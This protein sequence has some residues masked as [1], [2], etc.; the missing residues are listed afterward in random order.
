MAEEQKP[1]F[2]RLPTNVVPNH[3]I[4]HLNPN[5]KE[6]KFVGRCAINIEIK[7]CTDIIK[8]NSSELEI[9]CAK[10]CTDKEEEEYECCNF[11]Y[12][13]ENE[14][15]SLK[16]SK[17]L[18][19]MCATLILE[20]NGILNDRMQ[21]FYRSAY[22]ASEGSEKFAAV[23]QFEPTFARQCF[24]CW[25]EPALKA[26]FDVKLTVPE[27]MT[28]LSNM[29]VR[30]QHTCKGNLHVTFETSPIMSTYLLAV[31]IGEY[32]FVEGKSYEGVQVRVFTPVGKKDLGQY[33][34]EIATKSL[35]FFTCYFGIEYPLKKLD[36]VGVTNF[37]SGA[38][39][40]WGLVTFREKYILL[41][42]NES[43][44][45]DKQMLIVYVG[46]EIAHQWFGNLVTMEWWTHLWLNEGYA[47]FME[48]LCVQQMMPDSE[49]WT[50]FISGSFRSALLLDAKENSHPIEIEIGHPSEIA[51]T[52]DDISYDKGATLIKMLHNFLGEEDFQL[53]IKAYL[54]KHKYKNTQTE[55]LWKAFEDA[56]GK[57]VGDVMNT[58]TKQKGYPILKVSMEQDGNTRI[59][60]LKQEKFTANGSE[61]PAKPQWLI[62]IRIISENYRSQDRNIPIMEKG[63]LRITLTGILELLKAYKTEKHPTVWS[64]IEYALN[65]LKKL[66]AF[67][68]CWDEF[69]LFALDLYSEIKKNVTWDPSP[70]DKH[71][72]GLLRQM[73][74]E[75]LVGYGDE[76]TIKEAKLRYDDDESEKRKLHADLKPSAI[77]AILSTTDPQILD[78]MLEKY[79]TETNAAFKIIILERLSQV[80]TQELLQKILDFGWGKDVP[81]QDFVFIICGVAM[82]PVRENAKWVS[83]DG[84]ELKKFLAENSKSSAS[85]NGQNGKNG[86]GKCVCK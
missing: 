51:E 7:E 83:R 77:R 67:A 86:T 82:N 15:V 58:W 32:D 78:K 43:T 41:D 52:F 5:L 54:N 56:S 25:D 69:R 59:V 33:C 31:V 13:K 21:G 85:Q 75:D 36:L 19:C 30:K 14:V 12:D 37:S 64:N 63:C 18:P 74:I 3:Y 65:E 9:T 38:M 81:S 70:C 49:I 76:D 68:E 79:K 6:F 53:G 10:V 11:D 61:D 23:T 28:A 20:F 42:L 47:Q 1:V 45:Y 62:P 71:L 4:L 80:Q 46:H 39:E 84:S 48:N 50:Q 29:P 55:D 17:K 8:L 35:S 26:T 27:A 40:N 72:D 16:F 66:A 22:T 73:I 2:E 24:P 34:L 60:I 57:P 44:S